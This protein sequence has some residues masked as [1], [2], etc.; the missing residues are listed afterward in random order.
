MKKDFDQWNNKKKQIE[1]LNKQFLFKT[2]DIWWCSVGLNVG[3]ES[4]GKGKEYR[5]PVLVF[6]KL[7]GTDFL[8]IPLTTQKKIGT[9]FIDITIHG[10]KRY[11]LL[12]QIR[13]F[14]T[15]RFQRRLAVLDDKD[16]SRVQEKL[17]ALLEL[18]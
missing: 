16:F 17:K 18:F 7:S 4:C 12:S 1:G 10:E 8:G 13:M 9:W 5:R 15:K 11:A 14:N 3:T 2:G 6:K